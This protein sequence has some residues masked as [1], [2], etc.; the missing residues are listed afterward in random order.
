LYAFSDDFIVF[1]DAHSSRV[2]W[3]SPS[4]HGDIVRLC[5][6]PYLWM[7]SRKKYFSSISE[8]YQS[9]PRFTYNNTIEWL[10]RDSYTTLH[11]IIQN[12]LSTSINNS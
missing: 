12:Y 4:N 9:R 2:I 7:I 5:K 10:R 3:F 1:E 6:K 8:N 11:F